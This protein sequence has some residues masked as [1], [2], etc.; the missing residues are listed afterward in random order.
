MAESFLKKNSIYFL[1]AI[2]LVGLFLRVYVSFRNPAFV[3][4]SG[5]DMIIARHIAQYGERIVVGHTASGFDPVFYYPPYYY[6]LLALTQWI[7]PSLVSAYVLLVTLHLLAIVCVYK[8]TQIVFDTVVALLASLLVSVSIAF[9]WSV[10]CITAVQFGVPIF[11]GA[12]LILIQTIY[13]SRKISWYMLAIAVLLLSSTFTYSSIIFV[14]AFIVLAVFYSDRSVRRTITVVCW[15]IGLF[16]FLWSPLVLY[17]GPFTFIRSMFFSHT[18]YW[19]SSP[20]LVL[21]EAFGLVTEDNFWNSQLINWIP[22][23]IIGVFVILK[24]SHA[25]T[26]SLKILSPVLYVLLVSVVKRGENDTRYYSLVEPFI[27]VWI[28]YMIVSFFHEYTQYIYRIIAILLFICTLYLTTNHFFY[29]FDGKFVSSVE[30]SKLVARGVV[31]YISRFTDE[32]HITATN[33]HIILSDPHSETWSS[34]T[35][36]YWLELIQNRKIVSLLNGYSG[37]EQTNSDEYLLWVCVDF[38]NEYEKH[39]CYDSYILPKYTY[40]LLQTMKFDQP[41]YVGY[42]LKKR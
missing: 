19:P 23:I 24:K 8:F 42:L 25:V 18:L 11:W 30:E 5:R 15:T 2:V 7:Y 9:V 21:R 26:T 33:Y 6:Y 38:L 17:Y 1:I 41:G 27:S 4:D 39:E 12:S 31:K 35:L 14:P 10:T 3:G 16:I 37:F 22:S 32:F 36:L 40:T 28:S 34:S 13:S 29:L 20:F